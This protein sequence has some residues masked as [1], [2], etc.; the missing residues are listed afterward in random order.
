VARLHELRDLSRDSEYERLR[1]SAVAQER[2]DE[3]ERE[4]LQSGAIEAELETLRAERDRLEHAL[5][6]HPKR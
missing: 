2:L 6:D 4:R 1:Q 5:E 3:D